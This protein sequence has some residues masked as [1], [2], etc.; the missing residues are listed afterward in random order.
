[1]LWIYEDLSLAYVLHMHH[2]YCLLY[3][4]SD[5]SFAFKKYISKEKH[6][7]SN[8]FNSLCVMMCQE[9]TFSD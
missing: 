7:S 3:S 9:M 4:C 2:V 6:V 5:K 1:M 8:L